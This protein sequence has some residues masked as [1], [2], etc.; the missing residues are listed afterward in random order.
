M[1]HVWKLSPS[2]LTFLWDECPQC[3]YLKI[4]RNV[5][6]PWSPMP[7]IFTRIH[8]LLDGYFRGRPTFELSPDLPDGVV[9]LGER[10]VTS[11]PIE[12]PGHSDACF[13]RG[14]F[15]TVLA[16]SDSTYGVSDFK[17]SEPRLEHVPF[18]SRQLHAYAYALE[19]PRSGSLGLSPVTRLGL[20]CI[21]PSGIDRS[22]DGR[23]AYL[24]TPTW[25]DCPKDYGQ[26]LGFLDQ[27]LG[28]LE[29]PAP[30]PSG[31]DCTWCSYRGLDR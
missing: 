27:V 15:D 21:E 11:Q 29:Q 26:F 1:S 16:F 10:W 20:L 3:F 4:V 6:R 7:S 2:D 9:E 14:R 8:D 19:H 22:D 5:R 28:V 30:P 13:V 24:G 25:L 18:Y 17:T 23:L 31:A 12:L